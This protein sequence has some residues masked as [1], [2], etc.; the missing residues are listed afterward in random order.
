[1]VLAFRVSHGLPAA[2]HKQKLLGIY[3]CGANIQR[4]RQAWVL[5]KASLPLV[6]R[7]SSKQCRLQVDCLLYLDTWCA[8]R[9]MFNS[10]KRMRSEVRCT[11]RITKLCMQP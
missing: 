7:Y 9:R 6:V 1:M 4:M 8:A 11:C 2:V 5:T 10:P 3:A